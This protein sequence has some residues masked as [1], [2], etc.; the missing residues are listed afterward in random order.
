MKHTILTA[1]L[2]AA[3]TP[4]L[5]EN[6][7]MPTP[8]GDSTF[9]TINIMQFADDI[10]AATDGGL[11]ITIHSA[12]SLFPHSEI[13]NA[14]RSRQVAAGEFFLSQLNNENAAF[15]LDSQPFLATSYE[16]AARLWDA[17]KPVIAELLAEQGLVRCSPF[18]GRHR[19]CIPTAKSPRWM[20]W[21]ACASALTTPSSRNSHSWPV[22]PRFRLRHPTSHKPLPRV[23]SPR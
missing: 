7:D 11:D 9:H 21:P 1:A 17:Q 23:R 13:K 10:R 12:G 8:Y 16:D 14:V 18:H 6:W 4:T 5:A 20:I 15:G 3:A 19:A 22:P 2:L